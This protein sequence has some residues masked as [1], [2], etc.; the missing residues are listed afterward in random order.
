[1][2]MVMIM[3]TITTIMARLITDIRNHMLLDHE[4]CVE[5]SK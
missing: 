2:V 5:V 4:H 3:A 1:M